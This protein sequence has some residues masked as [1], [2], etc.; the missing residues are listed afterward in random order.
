[1]NARTLLSMVLFLILVPVAAIAQ[2]AP[3][4]VA[5]EPPLAAELPEVAEAPDLATFFDNDNFLGVH[6]EEVTR[7]N[8]GTYGLSGEPRGVAVTRLVKG[9]PAERAGLREKDVILR[10]DGEVVTS[11]R[12]LNRLIDES[13][14][15]HNAR[16][17]VS[18]GGSEQEISVKLGKR[19]GFSQTFEGFRLAPFGGDFFHR[20]DELRGAN[21]NLRKRLEELG[22]NNSGVYSFGFGGGRRI[23]VGTNALGKQLADYFG[24]AN[25]VLIHSVEENSPAAK[26][27]I[28]AG[29]IVTEIDG[30][31]VKDIGD[32]SRL[33]NKKEEGEVTLTVVRDKQRRTVKV[34]PEKR[35]T[36]GF[37]LAPRVFAVPRVATTVAAPRAVVPARVVTRP[38]VIAAPRVVV[39]ARVVTRPAVIAAPAISPHH[40]G[41]FAPRM[42]LGIRMR[43]DVVIER[44]VL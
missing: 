10:F 19:S 28:K 23:G 34:T 15:E 4:A 35:P 13:S 39:P 7:E 16:L 25:G 20:G 21:E 32:V 29:D 42:G 12:K 1:M 5:V 17:S 18:R 31:Q 37:D 40:F 3:P 26:A 8:L 9:G 24:V 36:P 30:E 33:I 27:G 41:I 44:R 38:A 11:I 14:P 6:V 43:P 2:E 22:R